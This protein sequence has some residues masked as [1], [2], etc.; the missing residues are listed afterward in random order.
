MKTYFEILYTKYNKIILSKEEVAA[1]LGI[2]VRTL[3]RRL[4][5]DEPSPY[6]KDRHTLQF[7]LKGF[8]AYLESIE[9]LSA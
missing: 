7:P 1:E 5:E 6:R 3:T 2:S 8:A 9:A 4:F